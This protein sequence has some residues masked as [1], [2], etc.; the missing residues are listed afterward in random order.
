MVAEWYI[1]L[2]WTWHC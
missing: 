2:G 1:M